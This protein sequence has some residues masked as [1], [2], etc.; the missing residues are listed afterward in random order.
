ME[1]P[2]SWPERTSLTVILPLS[3]I[4]RTLVPSEYKHCEFF[5]HEPRLTS[6]PVFTSNRERHPLVGAR[7]RPSG[8][9]SYAVLKWSVCLS[10]WKYLTTSAVAILKRTI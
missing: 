6:R 1:L 7:K 9:K 5:V 2:C 4:E 8:V 3:V 10:S